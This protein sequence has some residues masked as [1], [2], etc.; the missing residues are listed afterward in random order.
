[1]TE[2]P[3]ASPTHARRSIF[4][5]LSHPVFRRI[6][7]ASL[8]S[9]LGLMVMGVGAAWAM[10]EMTN[11][12]E[13]VALVQASLMLPIALVSAPAGAAADMFD[14]R[15]VSLVALTISFTGASS[16]TLLAW[17]GALSPATLLAFCFLI[18]CGMALMGPSWQAS[19]GEQVPSQDLPAAVALN[20]ISWNLARSFGPAIGGAI[21]AA[22]GATAAFAGNALFYLPLMIV[23]FMWRR[24]REPARLPPERLARAVVSGVRYIAYSPQIRIVLVRTMVTGVLGGSILALTPIVTRDLLNG[25]ARDFG[26]M[27][28]AF[29]VGA[30]IGALNVSN[31]SSRLGSE[32][33][34]RLSAMAMGAG[35]AVVAMSNSKIVS[36]VALLV[37]GA[38]WT[39]SVTLFNVGIQLVAPRWVSGRALAAFQAA[40]S[41][42]V[43]AGAWLWGATAKAI[44]VADA[45]LIAS[46][47]LTLSAA[48]GRWM[49]MPQ[50]K[51]PTEQSFEALEDPEM[52]LQLTARS[53]PIVV[54]IEYRVDPKQARL[55]YA[56]MQQV[57]HSRQRNGAYGWS[58]ARDIAD[59]EL[60]TERYHCP[61]W[62]DYL[63]QRNRPTDS[64]RTLHA[65]AMEFHMGS[66]PV[67]IRRMLERPVG[68]VR[69]KDETPDRSAAEEATIVRT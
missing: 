50:V 17:H 5:P 55:F 32:N 64:E 14:R 62:L 66:E 44:G 16:M 37:T 69:W 2:K 57:Q 45:L 25:D 30:V 47:A 41:G 54:E 63:R 51:G 40:I 15:I 24:V 11:S 52:R 23:L 10:T 13:M 68:S 34:I 27:L 6:W 9:N 42:G 60:W 67:R 49:R 19:V 3:Q 35:V 29:G 53:G 39:A 28:G 7:F 18:G 59:P 22:F 61:T 65:R 56:V 33:A 58:I 26:I 1:M 46:V 31:F 8:T 21:V 38:G 48:L 36:G 12:P 4:S 43:A 20:G